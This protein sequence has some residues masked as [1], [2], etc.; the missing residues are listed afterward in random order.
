M[1]SQCKSCMVRASSSKIILF[2]LSV[3]ISQAQQNGDLSIM[4]LLAST[5]GPMEYQWQ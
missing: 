2:G 4:A 1:M 5:E 3:P